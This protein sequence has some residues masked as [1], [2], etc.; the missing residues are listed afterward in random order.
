[1]SD[2]DRLVTSKAI[3]GSTSLVALEVEQVGDG[4]MNR[5]KSLGSIPQSF[6]LGMRRRIASGHYTAAHEGNCVHAKWFAVRS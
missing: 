2:R 6:H 1:M 3:V 4:L 5:E